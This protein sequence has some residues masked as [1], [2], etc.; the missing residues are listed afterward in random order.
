VSALP[1]GWLFIVP[2]SA[3]FI[4]VSVVVSVLVPELHAT[5]NNMALAKITFFMIFLFKFFN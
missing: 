1:P 5:A 4:E 3:L 2:L